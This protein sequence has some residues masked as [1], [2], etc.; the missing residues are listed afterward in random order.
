MALA[1]DASTPVRWRANVSA[2]A[3]GTVTSASFTAPAGAVLVLTAQYDTTA[4][5]TAGT[6]TATDSGGL[7]WTLL[8]ERLGS[9]TTA[10][11]GSGIWWAQASTSAA[12]TVSFTLGAASGSYGTGQV[13][14]LCYVV[15]GADA[16]AVWDGTGAN[17]KG[18]STSTTLTT[19][20]ITAGGT[21]L[22]FVSD[23]EWNEKGLLTSSDLTI[24]TGDYPGAISVASGYKSVSNGA[25]VTG[26]LT[27][28]AAGPQHKWAQAILRQAAGALTP[29]YESSDP[30]ARQ[31]NTLLAY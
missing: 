20:S 7:T 14:C 31:G 22:L 2:S 10:G 17:N 8:A 28:G 25:A 13:S 1:I 6:R 30:P 15:T 3:G 9:D 11:G 24:D 18:G 21:G 29:W 26:S 19:T 12:R 23:C 5:W 4:A 27:A 16:A